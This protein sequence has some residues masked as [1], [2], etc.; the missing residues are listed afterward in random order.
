VNGRGL[1]PA[2]LPASLLSL[3]L[4]AAGCG[5]A[6]GEPA[7]LVDASGAEAAPVDAAVVTACVR[8]DPSCTSPAPSYAATVRPILTSACVSCH[9]PDSTEAQSSLATYPSVHL[10]FGAALGQVAA[11][12]MPPAGYPQLTAEER[13]ALLAWLACGAP[14]N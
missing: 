10:V 13:T 6:S 4:V 7:S 2:T 12:L 3:A 5:G 14:D 9:H 11:C 1:S 8:A